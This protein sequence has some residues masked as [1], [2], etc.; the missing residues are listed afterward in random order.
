MR[1]LCV[2][3]FEEFPKDGSTWDQIDKRRGNPAELT[4]R[5]EKADPEK[6]YAQSELLQKDRGGLEAITRAIKFKKQGQHVLA[7]TAPVWA[8]KHARAC[9][10]AHTQ[11]RRQ[12]A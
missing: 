3:K 9:T 4:S 8:S 2:L 10:H 7:I 11:N 5:N 6:L 12:E 1:L